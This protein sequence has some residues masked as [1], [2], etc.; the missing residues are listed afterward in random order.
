MVEV[1]PDLPV[2]PRRAAQPAASMVASSSARGSAQLVE[3]FP[4]SVGSHWTRSTSTVLTARSSRSPRRICRLGPPRLGGAGVVRG[5]RKPLLRL[6]LRRFHFAGEPSASDESGHHVLAQRALA[7]RLDSVSA[8][9]RGG[10]LRGSRSGSVV[11]NSRS[12]IE[13][14]PPSPVSDSSG[15]M[16]H[17][18]QRAQ[19][20]RATMEGPQKAVTRR[21]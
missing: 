21:S 8:Q 10:L 4:R 16:A 6:Q 1:E 11:R 12:M 9:R 3:P 2:Y 20:F 13:L 14:H 17:H 19:V 5:N 18:T 7:R 15:F